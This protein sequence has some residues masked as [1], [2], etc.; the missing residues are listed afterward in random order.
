MLRIILNV[1]AEYLAD[2]GKY[3]RIVLFE[4]V[5]KLLLYQASQLEEAK[6]EL[7]GMVKVLLVD[8]WDLLVSLSD[9][10]GLAARAEHGLKV[11][12]LVFVSSPWD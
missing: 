9:G 5:D 7:R 3:A 6:L 8:F 2:E 12:N 4:L 1:T 10:V 11:E